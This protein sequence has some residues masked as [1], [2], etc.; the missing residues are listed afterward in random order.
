MEKILFSEASEDSEQLSPTEKYPLISI[1]GFTASKQTQL[2][3]IL[4]ELRFTGRLLIGSRN[5][6]KWTFFI[7]FGR[8]IYATGG[9]HPVRRWQRN[10]NLY[11]PEVTGNLQHLQQDLEQLITMGGYPCWEYQLLT[12]WTEQKRIHREQ[13]NRMVRATLAEIFFD[14]SQLG[15]VVYE[16][17]PDNSLTSQLTLIKAEEVITT[18]WKQWQ[19]W[20]SAK[21]GRYSPNDTPII[22]DLAQLKEKVSPQTYQGL[23][24]L[25][26]GEQTL[27]DLAITMK[28]DVVSITRFLLPYL[29]P[30]WVKLVTIDD[31]PAPITS[32]LLKKPST[33]Q[34]KPIPRPSD[35]PLIA[36]VENDASICKT[37]QEVVTKAGYDYLEINDSLRSLSLLM[38][39]QPHF[40][41]LDLA[42]PV[43][44]GYELCS[45]L[46][47]VIAFQNTPIVILTENRTII[48]RMRAK[49]VGSTDFLRKPINQENILGMI[50]KHLKVSELPDESDVE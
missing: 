8:I 41:F 21:L 29:Q 27:R 5:Q 11:C 2:F 30:G 24:N 44:N 7:Y 46:R 49:L 10:L 35:K 43:T 25:L 42:M 20:R 19:A 6:K 18:A 28:R 38:Q 36:F 13:V 45:Q 47:K 40:I 15:E 32:S 12:L 14:I 39:H 37:M 33:P 31:L 48:D 17:Q 4:K 26:D 34:P 22:Q 50:Q 9:V 1:K 3:T 23:K 16:Y